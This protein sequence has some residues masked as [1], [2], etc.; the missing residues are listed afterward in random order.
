MNFQEHHKIIGPQAAPYHDWTEWTWGPYKIVKYFSEE[1][2]AYYMRDDQSS[3]H[4]CPP[5]D[6]V[7]CTACGNPHCTGVH[8]CWSTLEGAQE[9]CLEHAANLPW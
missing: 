6:V 8:K 4:V 9:S 1:F 7:E 2:Y 3:V 5:P